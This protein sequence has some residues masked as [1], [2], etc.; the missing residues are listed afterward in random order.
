MRGCRACAS[1]EV[2]LSG[3]GDLHQRLQREVLRLVARR[4]QDAPLV[5]KGGTA[6]VLTR[7]S[8]RFTDDLD[9]DGERR[10][11]P[12]S[13]EKRIRRGLE[14]AGMDVL[15]VST[16][17]NTATTM[18]HKAA[19]L[20]PTGGTEP[21]FLKVETSLRGAPDPLSIVVI[22][23][24][25]TYNART[26]FEHKLA[27]AEGR[28]APRDL[29]DLAYIASRH[30]PELAN[31]QLARAEALGA[32]M[33]ALADRYAEAFAEDRILMGGADVEETV[34]NL[35]DAIE[36]ERARRHNV[37][38]ELGTDTPSHDPG[39]VRRSLP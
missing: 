29:Y 25:R 13:V 1:N 18:R 6:L 11:E 34:L 33:N 4:F 8:P 16:V 30:G 31:D 9:F 2:P 27:A 10:I 26:L 28:T 3:L 5:L 37:E 19:F 24:I 21:S 32:D 20:D 36:V 23:E 17:K 22:D 38:A 39:A 35:R 12:R 15:R 7:G 14:D